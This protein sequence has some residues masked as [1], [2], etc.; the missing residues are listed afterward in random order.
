[1]IEFIAIFAVTF[2]VLMTLV[3]LVGATIDSWS[4]VNYSLGYL[5]FFMWLGCVCLLLWLS[6]GWLM[7]Y[8]S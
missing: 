6:W 5:D 7:G 1:M 8:L 4:L 2:F 3:F